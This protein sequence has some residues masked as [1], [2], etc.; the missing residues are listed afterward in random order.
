MSPPRIP[1]P[2][3]REFRPIGV[4]ELVSEEHPEQEIQILQQS[5]ANICE[6]LQSMPGGVPR[7]ADDVRAVLPDINP[8][9]YHGNCIE[10]GMAVDDVLS[11]RAA[12]AG[13][14]SK[15][16]VMPKRI[17][18]SELAAEHTR[19][20]IEQELLQA[21][22]GSR[23]IVITRAKD[24]QGH[25]AN[26]ANLEGKTY[27]IDGQLSGL[28]PKEKGESFPFIVPGYPY[29]DLNQN[30]DLHVFIRTDGGAS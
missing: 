8:L 23:G 3:G 13:N 30:F 27:W 14:S 7:T 10:C 25:T 6:A 19:E 21:G 11:G 22:D 26:V 5:H 1:P 15:A 9:A 29:D 17:G 24:G 16:T 18:G 4:D 12:V 2:P 28:A 20:S